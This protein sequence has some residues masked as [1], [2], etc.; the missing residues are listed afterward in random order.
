MTTRVNTKP[1]TEVYIED[2]LRL[3]YMI[4][5]EF[6]KIKPSSF[7]KLFKG[8]DSLEVS[9]FVERFQNKLSTMVY[10][11]RKK[12]LTLRTGLPYTKPAW[13]DFL[14]NVLEDLGYDK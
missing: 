2:I 11:N 6:D 8:E 4:T 10:T 13:D 12:D 7:K 3:Y 1:T 14:K 9:A 5:F